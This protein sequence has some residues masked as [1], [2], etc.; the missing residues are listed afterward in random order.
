MLEMI[1]FKL[2]DPSIEKALI[3]YQQLLNKY[4]HDNSISVYL[5][6][7]IALNDYH[8]GQS[9]IDFV[10]IRELEWKEDDLKKL[11]LIHNEI[12]K[13][14]DLPHFDGIYLTFNQLLNHPSKV[15][16]P[17]SIDNKFKSS[18]AF[19][20][21]PITWNYLKKNALVVKGKHEVI[22]AISD[23]EIIN[24]C[25]ENITKY[26]IN[27][28]NKLKSQFPFCIYGLFRKSI[29]WGVLGIIRLHATIYKNEIISKTAAAEYA[30]SAFTSDYHLII[31]EALNFRVNKKS[32]FKINP[33]KRK[34]LAINFM[35]EVANQC[36]Q[37]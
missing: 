29:T 35:N 8:V 17:H 18:G 37:K 1:D 4:F 22:V 19:A 34:K 21:N 10:T 26:W 13:R 15:S 16:A 11:K 5:V 30:K 36:I 9:D 2:Y 25:K 27:W 33:Y 12:S 7:S 20:A 6:G 24:W 14:R 3:Y 28:T 31:E 23:Q 32:T